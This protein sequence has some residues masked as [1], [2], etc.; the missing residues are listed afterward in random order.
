MQDKVFFF[1]LLLAFNAFSRFCACGLSLLLCIYST[2]QDIYCPEASPSSIKQGANLFDRFL[3][4]EAYLCSC[5]GEESK[6]ITFG[7]VCGSHFAQ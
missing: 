6:N 3:H 5:D 7:F 4:A 2:R 1:E